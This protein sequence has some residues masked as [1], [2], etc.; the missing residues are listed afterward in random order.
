VTWRERIAFETVAV[1]S[2]LTPARVPARVTYR[3]SA[4]PT[5][6]T[7]QAA[8]TVTVKVGGI[9]SP[10]GRVTLAYAGARSGKVSVDLTYSNRGLRVLRLPRLPRGSYRLTLAYSGT[11]RIAPV[12]VN[13]GTLRV[14]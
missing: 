8:V 6:A 1:P 11:G 3:R 7:R 10:P 5:P 9:Q 4:S 13:A 12:T 2:L 14:G